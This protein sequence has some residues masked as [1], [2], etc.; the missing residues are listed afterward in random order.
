MWVEPE[1]KKKL[2]KIDWSQNQFNQHVEKKILANPNHLF[3]AH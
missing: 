1:M 2:K 3:L